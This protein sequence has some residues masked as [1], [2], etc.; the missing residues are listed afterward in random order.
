MSG[1][2]EKWMA[3]ALDAAREA[4][5]RGEVP[6]GAC[7]VDAEGRLIAKAGNLTIGDCDPTGHAEIVAMRAAAK[8][9]G[10]YR[11]SGCTLY[12]TIEPCAMC[13]GALVHARI[14]RLVFGAAD[15]RFGAARTL[16]NIC[17]DPRLNHRM[18]VV[19]G[20]MAED[21]RGVMR[22]FFRERRG[23]SDR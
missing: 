1:S 18:E 11:L 10:N 19:E 7:V 8:S 4:S 6:V 21:C 13:A 5:E 17:D 3:V 23:A 16:F 14:A 12:T 20:V 9:I 15:E 22:E 2:D